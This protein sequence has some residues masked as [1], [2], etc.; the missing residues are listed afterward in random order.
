MPIFRV[1]S[2]LVYFAHVPKSA[3]SSVTA[4][5]TARFGPPAFL[6][7]RCMRERQRLLGD[8][9]YRSSPQH[10]PVEWLE[11][12][13]PRG[14]FDAM[15]AV[16]RHPVDRAVSVFNYQMDVEKTVAS[17]AEFSRWL[18]DLEH[19][20]QRPAFHLDNHVAPMAR[21]VPEG[22]RVFRM[23]DGLDGV[24]AW[25]DSLAGGPGPGSIPAINT[26]SERL[27]KTHAPIGPVEVTA[28]DLDRIKRIYAE[29][30]RRFGYE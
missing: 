28:E 30:F 2:K 14:F 6:D 4:Y 23:E 26:R 21:I 17:P 18:A 24:V 5:M 9:W 13:F 20:P 8:G 25:I 10:I 29:D 3:G 19:A 11:R 16:V 12:L 22:A 15:F 1:A 7:R 27:A